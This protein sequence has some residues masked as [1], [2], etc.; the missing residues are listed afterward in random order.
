MALTACTSVQQREDT[1]RTRAA[2]DLD[3]TAE[4]LDA[5]QLGDLMRY[6]DGTTEVV[7]GVRGCDQKAAYLV[8]CRLGECQA[9][10]NADTEKTEPEKNSRAE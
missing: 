9:L 1:V 6:D 8:R 2:F 3:C 7:Y 10:L 4:Q 5:A